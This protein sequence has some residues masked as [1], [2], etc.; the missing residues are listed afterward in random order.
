MSLPQ[1]P[2]PSSGAMT[3]RAARPRDNSAAVA[4][5]FGI[6]LKALRLYE[7]L[8]MLKAPR[9]RAGWRI[10]GQAEF[11]RLHAILSFKQLGLPLARIAELLRAGKA[12]LE[13]LLSV[14]EEMLIKARCDA[15]N[16]LTL[17]RIAKERIKGKQ[18]LGADELADLVR[19][20]SATVLPW[21]PELDEL[22]R[23]TF[24]PGHVAKLR[25]SEDPLEAARLSASWEDILARFDDL[26][27]DADPLSDDALAV[28]RRL[29]T[30]FQERSRG[31]KDMWNSSAQFWQQAINDPQIASQMNVNRKTFDFVGAVLSE[32]YRRDELKF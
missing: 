7:R 22:A 11:E 26:G 2:T 24:P 19:R 31:D 14:Q 6:S 17:V 13:A 8:G 1:G 16:A 18:S 28:G 27:P 32:L 15:D 29:I 30:M 9:T 23:R 21:T 5:R 4:E 12:D 3:Q 20:I 25:G 10:Y